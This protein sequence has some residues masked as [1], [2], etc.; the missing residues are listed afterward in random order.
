MTE[1][2]ISIA[3]PHYN[4]AKFMEETLAPFTADERV[5]EII[6]HD[7]KSNDLNQLK[8]LINKLK[9]PKIKLFENTNNIGCY[10]NKLRSVKKCT[11]DWCLLFDSDNR[12][13]KE[14]I[15]CLYNIESWKTNTIYAPN[16]AITFPGNPNKELDYSKFS[17]KEI[18]KDIYLKNFK[19]TNFQCL[20]NTCNYFLPVKNY[21]SCMSNKKQDRKIIDCLDSAVLFTDWI[22][23]SNY[24]FVV[25]GLQ[26][27]HRIHP[28][29]NYTL[30]KS[31]IY[32]PM[33]K[34]QLYNKILNIK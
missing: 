26:Y 25:D 29:S 8:L 21:K 19:S 17:N 30:G 16:R 9:C 33:V 27:Y 12:A 10:H 18:T 34:Q 2:K 14:F 20:I 31:R 6:I 28:N 24:I 7:D 5:N 32:E 11:N 15:D 1:R 13:S 4:N 23:S 3:I 22:A